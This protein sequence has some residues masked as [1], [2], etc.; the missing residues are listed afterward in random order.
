[1]ELP[2]TAGTDSHA[3][4]D[5]GSV[6]THFE[7]DNIHDWRDLV[8]ELRSGRYYPVD[9]RTQQEISDNL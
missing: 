8:R 7:S 5:I 9:L 6:A 2:G 3:V 1:M 4:H